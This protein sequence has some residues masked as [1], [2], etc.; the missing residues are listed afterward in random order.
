MTGH[1]IEFDWAKQQLTAIGYI[2]EKDDLMCLTEAGIQY[3]ADVME[4]AGME[5]RILL[6]L[7][8]FDMYRNREVHNGE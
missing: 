1:S 3:C 2:E 8:H 7:Y 4:K 5:K 6:A